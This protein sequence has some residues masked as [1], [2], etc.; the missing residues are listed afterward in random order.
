MSY[1][2]W[3]GNGLQPYA[4]AKILS[5]ASPS[6][7]TSKEKAKGATSNKSYWLKSAITP[8]ATS[9][10][11]FTND[12]YSPSGYDRFLGDCCVIIV[13]R[14]VCPPYVRILRLEIS[15]LLSPAKKRRHS[16]SPTW[17]ESTAWEVR[18]PRSGLRVF[19]YSKTLGKPLCW[20]AVCTAW[21]MESLESV[22]F[23]NMVNQILWNP[24][25]QCKIK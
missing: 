2:S 11:I 23:K 8:R 21:R 3:K 13:L 22:I 16:T 12:F 9:H 7:L 24:S 18:S 1:S 19:I 20:A 6:Y 10:F 14:L 4:R 17:E 5:E 15:V 25:L